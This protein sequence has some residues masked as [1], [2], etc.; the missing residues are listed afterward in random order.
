MSK[1]FVL[2][3]L[4]FKD[5]EVGWHDA[6]WLFSERVERDDGQFLVIYFALKDDGAENLVASAFVPYKPY[7]NS[8]SL[9]AKW[10]SSIYGFDSSGFLF[11]LEELEG[12]DV[13]V[14][15][16]QRV[17]KGTTLLRVTNVDRA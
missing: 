10:L 16:E 2:S 9:L 5:V 12:R 4:R 8:N 11:D 17:V 7:V 1:V 6:E 13:R 15:V 3:D 14:Y